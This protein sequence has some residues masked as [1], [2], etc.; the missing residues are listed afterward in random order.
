M[1]DEDSERMWHRDGLVDSNTDTQTAPVRDSCDVAV[2]SQSTNNKVVHVEPSTISL[3]ITKNGAF[4]DGSAASFRV[5]VSSERQDIQ[6]GESN[7]DESEHKTPTKTLDL[8][9]SVLRQFEGRYSSG[10]I[11]QVSPPTE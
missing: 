11:P 8:L 6:N 7:F 9:S 4:L 3:T 5:I 10:S 1:N 2:T